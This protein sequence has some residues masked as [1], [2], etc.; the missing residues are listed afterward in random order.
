MSLF[1]GP[2]QPNPAPTRG[3]PPK[4]D[5]A[6]GRDAHLGRHGGSAEAGLEPAGTVRVGN[7]NKKT[8][9]HTH[10]QPPPQRANEGMAPDRCPFRVFAVRDLG[11]GCTSTGW[12]ERENVTGVVVEE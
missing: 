3:Q 8:H 4:D 11:V 10:R 7:K 1:S 9:T 6:L 12:L 2:V 5:A